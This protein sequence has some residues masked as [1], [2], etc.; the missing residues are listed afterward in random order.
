MDISEDLKLQNC[1]LNSVRDCYQ[2]EKI[3][4]KNFNKDIKMENLQETSST[5]KEINHVNMGH[6][7]LNRKSSFYPTNKSKGKSL[8]RQ[9][10]KKNRVSL[11][12]DRKLDGDCFDI[13]KA[14]GKGKYGKV[15]L[16]R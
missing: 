8:F 11:M 3:I 13:I 14:I 12:L 2:T 16:V 7:T 10:S 6:K 1:A 15:F 5:M 9:E 4:S